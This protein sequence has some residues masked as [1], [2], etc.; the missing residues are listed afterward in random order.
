MALSMIEEI[1]FTSWSQF[2]AQFRE[3]LG[4]LPA[5]SFV[6][7]GQG[8]SEW[9]LETSFHR[10]FH[11]W[12]N[13]FA[14]LQKRLLENFEAEFLRGEHGIVLPSD[15]LKKWKMA[16]HY[17]LPTPLLDWSE[18]P[19]VAAFFAYQTA[20]D[21]IVATTRSETDALKERLAIWAL[22]G[23]GAEDHWKAMG[24]QI[25]P[26][27]VSNTRIRNQLGL[28]TLLPPDEPNLENCVL[29][30]CRS[31]AVSVQE[32]LIQFTLPFHSIHEAMEDL[33]MMDITP[34]RLY[35]D[36]E[37]ACAAAALSTR[38]SAFGE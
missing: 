34:R 14:C 37:G 12:Q 15:P 17:K 28:F 24:V 27:D 1:F 20:F 4:N 6:F 29:K 18:S 2:R 11:L 32:L 19:Y 7:R 30:Y 36:L 33:S 8:D 26:G 25:L 23:N 38:L 35:G 13:D 31:A 3:H 9:K 22:R 16:Q 21:N 5:G 10:A